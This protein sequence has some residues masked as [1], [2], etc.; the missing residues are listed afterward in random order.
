MQ[1]LWYNETELG[2][3]YLRF[4]LKTDITNNYDGVLID[5]VKVSA[6]PWVFTGDEYDFKSGTSMAA[7]VVSGIAGLV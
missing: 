5:E 3:F 6:I 2:P 4:H 1:S 7:P